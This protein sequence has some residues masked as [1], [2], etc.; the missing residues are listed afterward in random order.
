MPRTGRPRTNPNRGNEPTIRLPVGLSA[1][2]DAEAKA[3]EAE[4]P[5]SIVSRSEAVRVLIIEALAARKKR[6]R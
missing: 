3:I 6:K 4:R 5:G 1:E 2:V